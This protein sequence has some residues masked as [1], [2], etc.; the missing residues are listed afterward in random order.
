M[1][2]HSYYSKNQENIKKGISNI[3]PFSSLPKLSKVVPGLIKEKIYAITGAT[4]SAKTKFTKFLAVMNTYNYA[5][6]NL[7]TGLDVK[8]IY[9]ALEESPEEFHDSLVCTLMNVKYGITISAME[10]NGYLGTLSKDVLSK[11]VS[12]ENDLADLYS[13]LEIHNISNPTGMYKLCRE[14]SRNRGEHYFTE[15]EKPGEIE[16]TYDEYNKLDSDNK[17]RFKYS[18]YKPNNPREHVIVITDHLNLLATEKGADTLS[19]SMTKW[20]TTYCKKQITKHWK[21]TCVHVHQQFMSADSKQYTSSGTSIADKL[22]PSLDGLGDNKI[23]ARDYYVVFG[24]F[25]PYR[26]QLDSELEYDITE[27]KNKYRTLLILK[28]RLGNEGD[29]LGLLFNGAS[30]RFKEMPN[31]T[32]TRELRKLYLAINK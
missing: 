2:R 7:N 15:I 26:Y 25:N 10:L 20:C 14:I 29:R 9:F 13:Y 21:W 1:K 6:A 4:G 32:D 23:V 27:L 30:D 17:S 12:I 16:L 22:Y 19:K 3:I 5:K 18:H 28:N 31:N 24:L 11:I 8:V